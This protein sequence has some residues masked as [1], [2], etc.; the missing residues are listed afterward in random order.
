MTVACNGN[1]GDAATTAPETSPAMLAEAPALSERE[2][3]VL[4][5]ALRETLPE[6]DQ[7]GTIF[8]SL[9][10]LASGWRDPPPQFLRRFNDLPYNVRPVSAA[11]LPKPGEMV[12]DAPALRHR[13]VEDPA[14]GQRSPIYWA[15]II[16]WE[17]ETRVRIDTGS[18]TGPLGGGGMVLVYE[19]R[20]GSWAIAD[21]LRGWVS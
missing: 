18:W 11:R 1:G 3:A 2:A 6:N 10:S 17:S 20:D 7:A 4:E 14:T 16:E 19:L 5:V 15:E 9:G 13:G 8:I 12:P 21:I